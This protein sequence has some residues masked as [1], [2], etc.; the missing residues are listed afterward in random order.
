MTLPSQLEPG[1]RVSVLGT[2]KLA[3]VDRV[4]DRLQHAG[5]LVRI[6]FDDDTTDTVRRDTLDRT[7]D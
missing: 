1:D 6:R 5:S 3:T 4:T 2:N 7:T